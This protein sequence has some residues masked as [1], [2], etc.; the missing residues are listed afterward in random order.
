M[1]NVEPTAILLDDLGA[2]IIWVKVE[3]VPKGD[4]ILF[5][6]F[7]LTHSIMVEA[8]RFVDL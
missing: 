2:D 7:I 1:L 5:L 4:D 3:E 6:R 8:C